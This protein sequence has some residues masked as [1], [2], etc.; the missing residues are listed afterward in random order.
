[1]TDLTP[2]Q[3]VAELDQ[4][5]V[6]QADAKRAV[7]VAVR[8]RW[9][10]RQL[11][12]DV[13]ANVLPKN[14][15]M[16]GPTGVG[17]TEIA[18]R[19]ATLTGAPF[20]KVE[21]T[22]F[23]E[24]GYYGRDVE[25][26]IRDL[27][28][29]SVDLVR[30]ET[31]ET[32]KASAEHAVEERLLTALLPEASGL[33][34]DEEAYEK[35]KRTR[36]KFREQLK[37]GKLEETEVEIKLAKRTQIVGMLGS[38]PGME[39]DPSMQGMLENVL[40]EQTES[41]K[42]KV[43]DARRVLLEAEADKLIDDDKIAL[44][45]IDRVEQGGIVFLDEIDKVVAPGGRDKSGASGGGGPGVSREGV[46]RDLLPIVE[47]TTV[48]TKHGPVKTDHVLFSAA[49]AFHSAKPADLMPELQGRFPIR[50]SLDDLTKADFVRV[51]TEPKHSLIEQQ[52]QLLAAEG[53]K[54]TFANDAI[55]AIAQTAFD[56]NR[57]QQNIGARRLYTI[58]ERVLEEAS[59][60][61][62]DLKDKSLTIDAAYVRQ[63]LGE[64]AADED[65]SQFIL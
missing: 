33:K 65:L 31:R 50:V 11:D 56:V 49:G 5:I 22:K 6:G 36:E 51:L 60:E 61:A 20:I 63:H 41:K 37:A 30:K 44:E 1:M 64:A 28:S 15:V 62:P 4:H 10:R 46:Q 18:R 21:A 58:L 19:L 43:K 9:R 47:G 59:F 39:L 13:A 2:R 45:A 14:I 42:M 29:V 27:V 23:T 26:I 55:D 25:S 12:P 34:T 40:P 32:V 53:L 57:R 48:V 52:T 8:N 54:V 17:K 16:S 35:R 7:A 38:Q 3:L 24:V